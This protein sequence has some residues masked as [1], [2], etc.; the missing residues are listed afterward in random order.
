MREIRKLRGVIFDVDGVL[1]DSMP[2]WKNAGSRYLAACGRVARSDLERTLNA[3]S[4]P[5]GAAYMKREYDLSASPEEIVRAI[6]EIVRGFYETEAPL[7]PG[8]RAFLEKLAK[9]DIALAIATSTDK[10][11]A[12]AALRRNGVWDYFSQVV[13]CEEA[14]AGKTK[15]NVY[16]LAAERLGLKKDELCLFEDS[17]YAIET[18]RAAGFFVCGVHDA[19][20]EKE[21]DTIRE[22]ANH[23]IASFVDLLEEE[24]FS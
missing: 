4:L 11:M 13:T 10:K 8:V 5:E 17:L 14:G 12:E 23:Y 1:L 20:S 2:I 15:P 7:K 24:F 22:R 21:Q 6:K 9:K 19:Y 3:L 18:A 16:L